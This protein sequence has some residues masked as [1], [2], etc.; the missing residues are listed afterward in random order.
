[1]KCDKCQY[2][3]SENDSYKFQGET[4]CDD[5]YLD[6]ISSR[7]PCDPLAVRLATSTR[8]SL[9]LKSTE[10]L[11]SI[12]KQFYEFIKD[13]KKVEWEEVMTKLNITQLELETIFVTLRHCEL[14]RG[15]QEGNIVYF[16]PF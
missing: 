2:D 6:A 15:Q 9:G 12:Q 13:Q 4:L 5:C 3:V 14:V 7:N 8:E 10:G 1:M 16:V 11:T